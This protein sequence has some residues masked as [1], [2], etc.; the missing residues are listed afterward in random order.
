MA[1]SRWIW[2][3]GAAA[4][5]LGVVAV[6]ISGDGTVA[7]PSRGADTSDF[8]GAMLVGPANDPEVAALLQEIRDEWVSVGIDLDVIT[9]EEIYRM[10][11]A[12]GQPLAFPPRQYLPNI[13][14]TILRVYLPLRYAAG[15]AFRITSGYRPPDYNEAVGGTPGSRH[16]SNQGIDFVPASNGDRIARDA[17][18]LYVAE[19]QELGMGLGIYGKPAHRLHI[20]TGRRRPATWERTREYIAEVTA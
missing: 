7:P 8:P 9:P 13:I 5:G 14:P 20:D 11:K 15:V 10:R 6:A 18:A 12:P 1:R 2:I 4:L 19:A 16:Q 17:A 3:G